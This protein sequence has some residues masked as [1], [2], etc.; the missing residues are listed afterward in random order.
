MSGKRRAIALAAIALAASGCGESLTRVHSRC[1]D[2]TP[3]ARQVVCV[4]REGHPL[5]ATAT[6]GE[7]RA[8]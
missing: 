1:G 7:R 4:D 3:A 6:V 2:L 5:S 8:K